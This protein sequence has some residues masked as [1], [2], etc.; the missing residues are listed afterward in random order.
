MISEVGALGGAFGDLV[1]GRQSFAPI[2]VTISE[3]LYA[4]AGQS[5]G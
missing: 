1:A 3:A 5:E 4:L 2:F